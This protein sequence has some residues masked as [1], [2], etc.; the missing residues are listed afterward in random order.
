[1]SEELEN[2][3]NKIKEAGGEHLDLITESTQFVKNGKDVFDPKT[4]PWTSK[5][6]PL[7]GGTEVF[8]AG[9]GEEKFK[10]YPENF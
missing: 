8:E 10:V 9:P 4:Q 6:K 5:P 1:M 3:L 7:A 2:Q